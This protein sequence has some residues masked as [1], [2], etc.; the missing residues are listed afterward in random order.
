M[1]EIAMMCGA[2]VEGPLVSGSGRD[3]RPNRFI[4]VHRTVLAT[5]LDDESEHE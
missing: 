1:L 5:G 3:R 2:A 4:W